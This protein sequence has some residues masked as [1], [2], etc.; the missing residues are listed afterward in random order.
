MTNPRQTTVNVTLTSVDP[1]AGTGEYILDPVGPDP[2]PRPTGPDQI[3]TFE[4]CGHDGVDIDFVLT[5]ATG[6]NYTF[7]PD[8]E[9]REAVSS[10]HGA[11]DLCP[12][13]GT[14]EVLMPV[15]VTGANNNTL[16]VHNPN[17]D[18]PGRPKLTGPFSYVLWLTKDR[19]ST[20]ISLDPGGNNM[21]GPTGRFP[22]TAVLVT[23]AVVAAAAVFAVY[24]LRAFDS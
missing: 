4:N 2:L 15:S 20:Y 21:N 18:R 7:P 6:Q 8:S 3:L 24:K 19:G 10:Q 9:K 12:E 23:T 22:W 17:Q 1:V 14:S 13:Q 16:R 5:D 11:T